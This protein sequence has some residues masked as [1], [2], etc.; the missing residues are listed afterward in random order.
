[1]ADALPTLLVVVG[2]TA[3]GKSAL[4]AGLARRFDGEVI[5]ADSVQ[6][7][8]GLDAGSDKPP[9]EVREEIPHHLI[10]VQDPEQD[11]SAGDYARRAAGAIGEIAARGRRPIVAGGT[12]LYVRA[13]LRGL[14]DMPGRDAELRRRLDRWESRRGAGALHGMLAVLDPATAERLAPADRQRIVRAIE[15]ALAS[16]RPLSEHIAGQPFARERYPSIKVGLTVPPALLG[17]RIDERVERFF[18]EGLVEEVRS[19]LARGVPRSANCFKALGYRE[20]LRH[21]SGDL[22]IEQTVA[23]VKANTRRYA[24]RQI[25]WFRSEQDVRWF[26][27]REPAA[28]LHAAIEV[29]VAERL[30]A[31]ESRDGERKP[32]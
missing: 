14:V 17:A 32:R 13:L 27:A 9:P 25:A 3:S 29:H 21:I 23:L 10:D 4:A 20:V 16:G 1:M 22:G 15:V 7:Y 19:L 5:G 24:R 8:R 11:F 28:D 2:P 12:G 30:R 18:R 31:E 6:V 26:E